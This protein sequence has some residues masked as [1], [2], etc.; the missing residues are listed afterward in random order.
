M[1]IDQNKK[2]LFVEITTTNKC[3]CNCAYCFEKHNACKQQTVLDYEQKTMMLLLNACRQFDKS[4][5]EWLTIS[6]WGG[7]PF[8]NLEF[9]VEVIQ[10]TCQFE[11][12]RYNFFSN[13][14]LVEKYKNFLSCKFLDKVRDRI[15][16]QLS[17]DGEPHHSLKRGD[18]KHLIFE[19]AD[20][21][22]A[23]K[24]HFDFKATLSFDMIKF[25]PQIWRSYY[26]LYLRYGNIVTYYPTLDTTYSDMQYFEDW[27]TAI[28][29]VAKLEFQFIKTNSR[30][31]FGWFSTTHKGNCQLGNSIH[32]HTDGNMYICHG[33]AYKCNNDN[34]RYGSIESCKNL[35][36]MISDK[37]EFDNVPEQCKRCPATYCSVC[38]VANIKD[39][40]DPYK[41][42]LSCKVNNKARCEY[43]KYFGYISKLL[44]Y[45]LTNAQIHQ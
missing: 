8:L 4:K 20:M 34:L 19:V 12:V 38:H 32:I 17:Y 16:I 22:Q 28:A 15:H 5:F 40:D 33:C 35:Y 29:E 44:Q 13:G 3:N 9:I 45:S 43:F 36:D 6:F 7:E 2:S 14:T 31:L 37:F 25:L 11:F 42:W 41:V 18:N 30:F 10:N 21:L 39:N 24:I 1:T 23:N 26:D 27:K